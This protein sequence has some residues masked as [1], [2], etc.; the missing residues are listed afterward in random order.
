M[1]IRSSGRERRPSDKTDQYQNILLYIN[2]IC[3]YCMH[4][5]RSAPVRA[6]GKPLLLYAPGWTP[7]APAIHSA[8]VYGLLAA[9][10]ALTPRFAG[11]RFTASSACGLDDSVNSLE[12]AFALLIGWTPTPQGGGSRPDWRGPRRW[13]SHTIAC[14]WGDT[15]SRRGLGTP[16]VSLRSSANSAGAEITDSF[17]CALNALRRT[18]PVFIGRGADYNLALRGRRALVAVLPGIRRL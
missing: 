4:D 17:F 9:A 5:W 6:R 14:R 1:S 10:W 11:L 7:F 18:E 3:C 15:P 16:L 13:R 12:R 8:T 2:N